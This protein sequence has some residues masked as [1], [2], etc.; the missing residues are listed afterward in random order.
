MRYSVQSAED[1]AG[2][3]ERGERF[4]VDFTGFVKECVGACQRDA[5]RGHAFKLR[6]AAPV[7]MCK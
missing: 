5:A 2:Q 3:I 6:K 1:P 7:D 4:Q